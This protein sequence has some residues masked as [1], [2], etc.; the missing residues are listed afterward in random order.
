M[1][2]FVL[3]VKLDERRILEVSCMPHYD[4]ATITQSLP[5]EEWERVA[6]LA[7]CLYGGFE[8][9]HQVYDLF[10]K[11]YGMKNTVIKAYEKI[12]GGTMGNEEVAWWEREINGINCQ[13]VIERPYASMPQWY[14]GAIRF[15]NA[16]AD[17][18]RAE[19]AASGL[20]AAGIC[21]D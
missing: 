4:N 8:S 18:L 20:G 11:E 16:D 2:A 3:S 15:D 9:E 19:R 14:L 5:K 21:D 10:T 12:M 17:T 1:I 7:T 13:M 6:A